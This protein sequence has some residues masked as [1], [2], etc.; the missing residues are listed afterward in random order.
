MKKCYH[1]IF[2][3]KCW[4]VCPVIV[5]GMSFINDPCAQADPPDA[6]IYRNA[7][8]LPPPDRQWFIFRTY[9]AGV[10]VF[11]VILWNPVFSFCNIFSRRIFFDKYCIHQS[12]E[13]AQNVQ[14]VNR[15]PLFLKSSKCLYCLFDTQ[16]TTRLWYHFFF[17]HFLR[18]LFYTNETHFYFLS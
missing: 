11:F 18:T 14:G 17:K 7:C 6:V 12:D 3:Y 4:V 2:L 13:G 9:L 1:N 15:L 8:E 10:V 16:W 5:V